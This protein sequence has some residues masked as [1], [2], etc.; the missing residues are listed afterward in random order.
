MSADPKPPQ[1]SICFLRAMQVELDANVQKGDWN[2]LTFDRLRALDLL[3]EH[4]TKLRYSLSTEI[5]DPA[6]VREHAADLA[7]ISMK[8]DEIFG[9][10]RDPD[11]NDHCRMMSLVPQI[12]RK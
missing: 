11:V 12:L 7:N 3:E 10:I 2:T 9:P 4:A 1:L 5:F 6:K 8:I